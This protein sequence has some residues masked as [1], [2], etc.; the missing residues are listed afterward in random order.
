MKRFLFTILYLFAGYVAYGQDLIVITSGDSLN[1][2]ITEV[3]T[4]AIFFRY[5]AGGNIVSLPMN[6][7]ASYKYGF[8]RGSRST[9]AVSVAMR[10]RSELSVYAGGGLSS[11]IY[12][13]ERGYANKGVGSL[14]GIGYT[15]FVS[16]RLGIV[17]GVEA[18]LYRSKFTS[19]ERLGTYN[20]TNTTGEQFEFR[21]DYQGFL[22]KQSALFLQI[23]VM[24]QL[25]TGRLFASAGLKIGIPLGIKFD[26][27]RANFST[28]GTYMG[29]EIPK[30]KDKGLYDFNETSYS[31]NFESAF[32]WAFAFEGGG[33]WFLGKRTNLYA[34]L[35]FDIALNNLSGHQ[36]VPPK[37]HVVEYDPKVT[38]CLKYYSILETKN[39]INAMSAG[40]KVKL[41]FSL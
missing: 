23:P 4:D 12:E 13:R 20:A 18:S 33:Q 11:L 3:K 16:G 37:E 28:S 35:W 36:G 10:G 8:Y 30:D 14:F 39:W 40:L 26:V 27:T 22:E 1:C 7:V 9:P 29:Y 25:Q 19:E 24:A 32:L 5:D 21:Y 34:G 15:W 38:G 2:K 17:T 6:Q 41:S 31:G